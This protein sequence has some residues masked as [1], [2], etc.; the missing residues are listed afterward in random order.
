MTKTRSE[1]LQAGDTIPAG[2]LVLLT[3]GT[4]DDYIVSGLYR[5][6]TDTIIP[7]RPSQFPSEPDRIDQDALAQLLEAVPYLEAWD[8]D[9]Y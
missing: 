7:T 5:A 4:D 1:P 3:T 2:T 6:T 9:V 8:G